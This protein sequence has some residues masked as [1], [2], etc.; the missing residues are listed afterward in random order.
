[1]NKR[2]FLNAADVAAEL[3]SSK[4]YAYKL[5]RILNKEQEERGYITMPGK[6]S[7]NYFNEKIY[8][9]MDQDYAGIQRQ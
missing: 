4:A 1:M 3:G 7:R 2:T 5:I 6:V 9:G 8:G